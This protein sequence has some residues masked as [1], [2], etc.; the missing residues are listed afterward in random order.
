MRKRPLLTAVLTGALAVLSIVLTA[1][2]AAAD[3]PWFGSSD[4]KRSLSVVVEDNVRGGCW[5]DRKGTIDHIARTL[6]RY[7]IAVEERAPVSLVLYAVGH[8]SASG[9]F[10]KSLACIGVLQVRVSSFDRA[11]GRSL[12][13]TS[14]YEQERLLVS[15]HL[16]DRAIG[17]TA[18][19]LVD[20]F[21]RRYA[22]G[23]E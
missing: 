14:L 2:D 10:A 18:L 8:P 20:N 23:L 3:F 6:D 16:L 9:P 7:G 22:D 4:E 1:A 19:E 13:A 12:A 17:T 21:S 5:R 11:A 15:H